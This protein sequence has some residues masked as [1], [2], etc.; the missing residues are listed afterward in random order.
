M[1]S[2]SDSYFEQSS[3]DEEMAAPL[4]INLEINLDESPESTPPGSPSPVLPQPIP[5]GEL[6]QVWELPDD[7]TNFLKFYTRADI[8]ELKIGRR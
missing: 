3:N 1:E 4:H 2:D 7:D 6:A 5:L 8:V